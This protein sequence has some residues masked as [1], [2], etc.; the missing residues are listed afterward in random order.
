M[1]Q[2][3]QEVYSTLKDATEGAAPILGKLAK[4]EADMNSGE[5]SPEYIEETLEPMRKACRDELEHVKRDALAASEQM[6]HGYASVQQ[7]ALRLD[8]SKLTD[9]VKLFN[10]GVRLEARDL[11]AIIDRSKGNLTMEQLAYRYAE[12]NG[13]ELPSGYV[14]TGSAEAEARAKASEGVLDAASRYTSRYFGDLAMLDRFF[15]VEG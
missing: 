1:E 14:F 6:A 13:V 15:S 2:L 12:Q 10:C 7:D 9:D 4:V 5:Y 3:Q 8:A 11:C